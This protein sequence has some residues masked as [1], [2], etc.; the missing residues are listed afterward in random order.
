MASVSVTHEG[1]GHGP[2]V[3]ASNTRRPRRAV[4][5]LHGWRTSAARDV[6]RFRLASLI[7]ERDVLVAPTAAERSRFGDLEADIIGNAFRAVRAAGMRPPRGAVI[8][9]HSGGYRAAAKALTDPRL[10]GVALLDATYG[11]ADAYLDALSRGMPM[12]VATSSRSRD[13][14]PIAEGLARR[15]AMA[16][17]R[18]SESHDA[19]VGTRFGRAVRALPAPFFPRLLPLVGVGIAAWALSR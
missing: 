13:T 5:Y 8:I 11:E 12:Y 10:Q 6:E 19:I 2:T 14:Q 16:E 15:G 1:Q 9:A 7:G 4:I 18:V 3:V 17:L